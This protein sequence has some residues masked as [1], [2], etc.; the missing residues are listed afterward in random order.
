[1][2]PK[3][4]LCPDQNIYLYFSKCLALPHL[5]LG[6]LDKYYQYE[7]F[8][9]HDVYF[10]HLCNFHV[11][12]VTTSITKCLNLCSKARGMPLEQLNSHT[13]AVGLDDLRKSLLTE[14]FCPV[15]SCPIL[16][17]TMLLVK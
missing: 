15:L 16:L 9:Q 14:L 5:G 6:C 10:Q 4:C 3:S 7:Q 11:S 13:S 8:G 12:S 1:M 17:I 2:G